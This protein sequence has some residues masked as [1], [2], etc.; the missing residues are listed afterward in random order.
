M[1]QTTREVPAS[2]RWL[3]WAPTVLLIGI[4][5]LFG[6]AAAAHRQRQIVR[7]SPKFA[8]ALQSVKPLF[9]E[10]NTTPRVIKRYQ[11]RMRYLAAR[12]RPAGYEPDRIDSLLHWLGVRLGRSLVP[13]AWFA[14]RS[15]QVI[16]EPALILLG[17][18]ELFAP[19]AFQ[20]PW[21]SSPSWN[22][23]HRQPSNWTSKPHG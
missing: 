5:L 23:P 10:M 18:V 20:T 7:D 8:L 14:E 22:K 4:A 1:L 17:A 2:R 9:A 6:G 11:N 12:L 15:H 13:T 21:S 19:K 16:E 3:W